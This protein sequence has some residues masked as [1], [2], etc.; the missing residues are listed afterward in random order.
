MKQMGFILLVSALVLLAGCAD[1]VTSYY[2][3]HPHRLMRE[4]VRCE[5]NG[6]ALADTPRCRK[7]LAINAQLF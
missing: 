6:G 3:K 1:S 4:V 2:H 5:N 7:A